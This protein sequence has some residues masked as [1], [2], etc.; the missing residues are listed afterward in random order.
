VLIYRH[1]SLRTT[2]AMHAGQPMQVIHPVGPY[3]LPIIDLH[4]LGSEQAEQ[5]T[6]HL[7]HQEAQYPCNLET[8]PLLRTTL[9]QLGKE[10]NVL[11][12]TLHHIITDGW[13]NGV[14][15][16]E[17][18]T[19]YQSMRDGE[20]ILLSP[21]SIQYA[22]YALWQRDWLQGQVLETQLAYWRTQL[23]GAPS[24]ELP[25]DHPR[26]LMSTHRGAS[27]QFH[28]P[29]L[30]SKQLVALSREEHVTLFMLLLAAFQVLLARYSGQRDI[31]VGTPIAN[32]RQIE[33]EEVIGFFVNTLVM[34]TDLSGD[35]TFQQVLQRVRE[36]C[37]G[38]YAHQDLP[39]EKIVEELVLERDMS[40]SPLFQVMLTLQNTLSAQNDLAGVSVHSL[41]ME[42]L[43]SQFDLTLLLA[44]TEQGLAGMLEYS[45]DLF[46][47][48]TIERLLGHWQ[49]LLEGIVQTPQ[50]H[51][52]ELP[53]LTPQEQVLL[54][55]W[56]TTQMVSPEERCVHELFEQ[57]VQSTPEAIA[58]I[59]EQQQLTYAQLNCRAN[60][61]AHH[62]QGMRVGPEVLVG[63]CMERSLDLVIAML[64]VLKAG[65]VYL[66]LDPSYPDERLAF[67]L[68]DAGAALV[69]THQ[70]V[71]K[72]LPV[73]NTP[74]LLL[75]SLWEKSPALSD[76]NP[77][78]PVS[79]Q[80]LAYVI[81]TSG[82]TGQP[83][84]V[85]VPHTNVVRLF[86]MTD[87]WFQF[88]PQDAWTLFHSAAFDFS[89]W[90]L[91]GA[92]LSG[93][94]LVVVPYWVSRSPDE[95][96]S[97]L[98]A[99]QIT[100]LNQTPSAFRQLMQA[101]LRAHAAQ[102]KA[103]RAVI[104]G[105]EALEPGSLAPWVGRYGDQQ[106]R[107]INMYGITETTV[108]VTYHPLTQ[109]EIEERAASVIGIPISE[110]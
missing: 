104:F 94:R 32:R 59:F 45:T 65:G 75:E 28:L 4:G 16:Q 23:A 53:L 74:V 19:L 15:I 80:N 14:L 103:L 90:D 70:H 37:L 73:L 46:K 57:Q 13:S 38:A 47:E 30:L 100:V 64:A 18:T 61:L 9:L 86:A 39:F 11:L 98:S 20:A 31:S 12:L 58:L 54:Q 62:L 93:G 107:L 102:E 52:W 55:D 108:H 105:G 48:E 91:W 82:S 24:L 1:E 72:P 60:Q 81:Y 50:A 21:Q 76:E 2:F 3:I 26:P 83:K 88:S 6:Q 40:R 49:T 69:L 78:S 36:G 51:I 33:L 5:Q 34:R 79:A 43:N 42:R 77:V 22:D 96:G 29:P 8:G 63:I 67:L 89:V 41:Q 99:E 17:L 66:P 25:T 110:W 68:Q 71:E 106:P 101:D 7:A 87:D 56:N 85:M 109:V 27:V 44:E 97:L 84:G 95:F 10:E 35:L 92:L